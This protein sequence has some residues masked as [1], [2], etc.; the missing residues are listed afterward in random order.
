MFRWLWN[1]LWIVLGLDE[2]A[3]RQIEA[4]MPNYGITSVTKFLFHMLKVGSSLDEIE[5][6]WGWKIIL[7]DNAGNE[8]SYSLKDPTAAVAIGTHT[9]PPPSSPKVR[10]D[11][12]VLHFD[13]DSKK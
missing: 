3:Q 6:E 11:G 12:N 10:R 5:R 7:R 4:I 1:T 9:S 13:F 2:R 8:W